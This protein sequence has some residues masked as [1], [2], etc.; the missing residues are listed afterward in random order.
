M[1][2]A[3]T[4]PCAS[5]PESRATISRINALVDS[6]WAIHCTWGATAR[7]SFSYTGTTLPIALPLEGFAGETLV[8]LA[9]AYR[10]GHGCRA[11][12]AFVTTQLEDHGTPQ[13]TAEKLT[14][15]RLKY[16]QAVGDRDAAAAEK[17]HPRGKMTARERLSTLLDP[18]SFVECDKF[19]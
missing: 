4:V 13:T 19:V 10:A 11:R 3:M 12:L 6:V 5:W 15:H 16:Q 8:S 9:E 7:V 18:G 17:Q 14:D 1:V 2:V